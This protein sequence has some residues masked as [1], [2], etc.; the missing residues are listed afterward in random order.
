MGD[1]RI[2]A[3]VCLSCTG[4]AAGGLPSQGESFLGRVHRRGWRVFSYLRDGLLPW[5]DEREAWASWDWMRMR[6]YRMR[7]DWKA[8]LSAWGQTRP[9]MAIL[10]MDPRPVLFVQ[11][12]FQDTLL[13]YQ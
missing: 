3:L 4:A 2:A 1:R 5:L 8:T 13:V 9:G 10:E 12:Q 7:I 11:L 6:G